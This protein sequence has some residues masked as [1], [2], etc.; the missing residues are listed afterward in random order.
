MGQLARSRGIGAVLGA[1]G[2]ST[3]GSPGQGPGLQPWR[4][5]REKPASPGRQCA[6]HPPP[7][8]G[9]S[10][11]TVSPPW[12]TACH[13]AALL[14]FSREQSL[15]LIC[16]TE[17]GWRPSAQEACAFP[18]L[19]S[20]LRPQEPMTDSSRCPAPTF[21]SRGRPGSSHCSYAGR[22][23]GASQHGEVHRASARTPEMSVLGL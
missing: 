6:V 15:C 20:S 7:S 11:A 5:L 13:L 12:G 17:T 10:R 21:L 2:A 14:A 8:Q 23:G 9:K 19:Q 3:G 18:E 22:G 1:R 4:P 16:S